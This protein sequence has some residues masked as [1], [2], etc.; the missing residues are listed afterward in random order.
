MNFKLIIF[1]VVLVGVQSTSAFEFEAE[2]LGAQNDL[3]SI[4]NFLDNGDGEDVALKD[5]KE[6]NFDAHKKVKLGMLFNYRILI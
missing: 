3:I 4:N 2:F 5:I 6:L 1:V